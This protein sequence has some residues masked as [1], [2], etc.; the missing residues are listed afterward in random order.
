MCVVLKHTQQ[1]IWPVAIVLVADVDPHKINHGKG[2]DGQD[3]NRR[4]LEFRVEYHKV[5]PAD[6]GRDEVQTDVQ[7][8]R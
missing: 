5:D 3:V 6:N 7:D 4:A 8:Q 2:V 1:R